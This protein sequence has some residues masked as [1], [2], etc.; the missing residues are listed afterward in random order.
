MFTFATFLNKNYQT[1]VTP[2]T[3]AHTVITNPP[4][5]ATPTTLYYYKKVV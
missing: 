3:T 2:Q 5:L 1:G 4:Q